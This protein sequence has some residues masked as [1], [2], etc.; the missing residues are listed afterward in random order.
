MTEQD[1]RC[2]STAGGLEERLRFLHLRAGLTLARLADELGTTQYAIARLE[3]G[4]HRAS[5]KAISRVA[6]ALRCE[7]AMSIEQKR[8]AR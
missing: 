1:Y 2:E 8:I 4:L 5:L 7:T 6:T 3:R